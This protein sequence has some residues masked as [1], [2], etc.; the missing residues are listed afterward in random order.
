MKEIRMKKAA[1]DQLPHLESD[2]DRRI[3]RTIKWPTGQSAKLAEQP[4]TG[5][6]LPRTKTAT[7]TPISILVSRAIKT[8]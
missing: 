8:A 4:W 6:Q 5:Y 3:G 7:F 2:R 1:R